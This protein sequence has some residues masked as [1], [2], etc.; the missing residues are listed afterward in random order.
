MTAIATAHR[1][2]KIFRAGSFNSM[3]G[4]K[5]SFSASDLAGMV[6]AYD[7][8]SDPAPIVVGHPQMNAPA[9][10]WIGGLRLEGEHI[11]A[12]PSEMLPEMTE[13]VRKGLYRK[14]SASFYPPQ[15]P[16]N[17]KP[18]KYYL[19]H[20]GFLGAAP[21]AVKGLGTLAFAEIGAASAVT[22]EAAPPAQSAYVEVRQLLAD[23][24]HMSAQAARA[25]VEKQIALVSLAE[26]CGDPMQAQR[27]AH[28]QR[29][30]DLQLDRPTL[31]F[32]EAMNEAR[33][34]A[35]LRLLS[36]RA[37][38]AGESRAGIVIRAAQARLLDSTLSFAEAIAQE[39][40]RNTFTSLAEQTDDPVAKRRIATVERAVQL[41]AAT[42][43]LSFGQ[44]HDRAC[45]EMFAGR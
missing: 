6:A 14:V 25:H 9:Y 11:V 26:N 18:G 42:P 28:V 36:E 41:Q 20:V 27:I 30:I 4:E 35:E 5:V 19:R 16:G 3:E 8:K 34:E 13:A 10:G 21:P 44:A 37:A 40:D 45:R 32:G 43:G 33:L 39:R 31:S 38:K 29:A 1:P 7:P 24:P 2:I 22:I 17:P 12:D 15:H 23:R